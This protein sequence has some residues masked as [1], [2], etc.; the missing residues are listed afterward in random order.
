MSRHLSTNSTQSHINEHL[1]SCFKRINKLKN[2]LIIKLVE[3]SILLRGDPQEASGTYLRGHLILNIIKS[4]NIKKLKIKFYGKTKTFLVTGSGTEQNAYTEIRE[5]INHKIQ[6]KLSTAEVSSQHNHKFGL[7]KFKI[8]STTVKFPVG[9]YTYPFEI[10]I[11]GNLPESVYTKYGMVKYKLIARASR[12][13]L[14][15]KLSKNL[16]VKII[17]ILPDYD[18]SEGISLSRDYN[19]ILNYEI[20]IPK[21]VFP[22]GQVIQIDVKLIPFIKKLKIHGLSIKLIEKTNYIAENN[23]IRVSKIV[24]IL[25]INDF[26]QDHL[27][28]DQEDDDIGNTSHHS[29]FDFPIPNCK[30]GINYS[31]NTPLIK[32]NHELVFTFK[33][34]LP[35]E[36]YQDLKNEFSVRSPITIASCLT[37]N[38]LSG[39][40]NYEEISKFCP[41]DPEYQ[42]VARLVLGDA[43]V[44]SLNC[45]SRNENNDIERTA[46]SGSRCCRD[47]NGC[48]KF[49]EC[50][51]CG[52]QRLPPSYEDDR[53]H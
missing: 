4:I 16:D 21:H 36:F 9:S 3:P 31:M 32:I 44:E 34:I 50:N 51:S 10:F 7:K 14:F 38:Q 19:S 33:I 30:S 42:R 53:A 25:E 47:C 29:N 37:V 15:S 35:Q 49:I 1:S 5:I 46:P 41:C 39:L 12:S 52:A 11:P 26:M 2:E 18:I 45:S 24:A 28:E 20:S 43:V 48:G 27:L 13:V 23:N 8:R 40:P 17:R 22:L 6:F